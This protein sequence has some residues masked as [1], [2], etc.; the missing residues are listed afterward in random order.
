ML[1]GFLRL[2]VRLWVIGRA[3]VCEI[4][5]CL[6]NSLKKCRGEMWVPVEIIFLGVPRMKDAILEHLATPSASIV[7]AWH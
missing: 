7:L 1:I 6:H 2:S 5:S 4:S 3:K